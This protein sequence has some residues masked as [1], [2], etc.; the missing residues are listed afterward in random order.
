MCVRFRGSPAAR[1][2]ASAAVCGSGAAAML[3]LAVEAS[4]GSEVAGM[5]AAGAPPTPPTYL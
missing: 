1:A 4:T 2:N 3:F 5:F